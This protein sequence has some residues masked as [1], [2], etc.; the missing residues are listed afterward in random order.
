MDL[1]FR[2][3]YK[4]KLNE[5]PA[6]V[7]EELETLFS[8]P[9]HKSSPKLNGHFSDEYTFRVRPVLSK[10]LVFFGFFQSFA[11]LDGRLQAE[12]ERTVIRVRARAGNFSLL[13]F[14]SILLAIIITTVRIQSSLT[15]E[16]VLLL[17]ALVVL[18]TVLYFILIYSR[19]S[20]RRYFQ[21]QMGI[22]SK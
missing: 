9:W 15:P 21:R 16:I 3:K 18:L 10:A 13:L 7:K 11:V 14:Y 19:N 5:S 8:T 20:L 6:Q 1:L 2:K 4:Y 17:S 12:E 22:K